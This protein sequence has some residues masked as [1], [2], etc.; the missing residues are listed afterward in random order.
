MYILKG[1]TIKS[2]KIRLKYCKITDRNTGMQ[3]VLN[4]QI[5]SIKKMSAKLS[6][7]FQNFCKIQKKKKKMMLI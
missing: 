2:I 5:T 7:I 6:N 4:C 1:I 3:N